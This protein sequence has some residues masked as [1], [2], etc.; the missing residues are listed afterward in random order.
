MLNQLWTFEYLSVFVSIIL[1]L[2]VLDTILKGSDRISSL[3][4]SYIPITLLAFVVLVSAA[5]SKRTL[6]HAFVQIV[7]M[8]GLVFTKVLFVP[9]PT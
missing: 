5:F 8:I 4:W 1:G 9:N 2:D 3:G 7:I 6:Y